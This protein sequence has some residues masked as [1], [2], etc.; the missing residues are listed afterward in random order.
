MARIDELDAAAVG[1]FSGETELGTGFGGDLVVKVS[2]IDVDRA[3]R[4]VDAVSRD[5]VRTFDHDTDLV[6]ADQRCRF[7]LR[8]ISRCHDAEAFRQDQF[9]RSA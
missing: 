5:T 7:S 9:L 1:P 6:G 4:E 2:R 8:S 3:A